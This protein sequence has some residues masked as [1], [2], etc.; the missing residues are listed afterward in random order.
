[1]KLTTVLWL[2]FFLSV[3]FSLKLLGFTLNAAHLSA[4]L[5]AS[6]YESI[7]VSQQRW[8]PQWCTVS[9]TNVL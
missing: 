3:V 4:N 1:M 8:F 7:C 6:F 2:L 9:N 5:E